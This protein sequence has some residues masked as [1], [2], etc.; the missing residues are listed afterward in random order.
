MH[1]RRMAT[2]LLGIWLGCGALMA[3]LV[4][5][6]LRSA[7]RVM[8][9]PS[10]PAAKLI[11][12]LGTEDALLL[13]SYQASEQ[14]RAYVNVWEEAQMGL[15]LVLGICLFLGTQKRILPLAFCGAMLLLV[16]FQHFAVAPELVFRGREV[17]FPPGNT[18]FGSRTRVLLLAQV[19][20]AAEGLKFLAGGILAVYLFLFSG[21]KRSRSRSSSIDLADER[22]IQGS[23]R[24]SVNP[25]NL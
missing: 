6:N 20:G 21:R 9:S 11:E 14:S 2:F 13:L 16:L 5:E 1:T 4:V 22:E 17:D 23:V 19:Y 3:L 18:A 25:T 10:A 15:A 24:S 12:K 8:D 7:S